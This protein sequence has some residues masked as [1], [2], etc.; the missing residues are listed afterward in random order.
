CALGVVRD[1]VV[2]H[3]KGYGQASLELAVPITAA[4]V[5]DIGSV[6][7]QIT[8]AS[9]VLLA[10]QGKLALDDDVRKFVPD[11]PDYGRKITLRHLLHHTS[12]LRNYVTLLT[13]AGVQKESVTTD[14]DA[15]AF[16]ARQKGLNFAPGDDHLY[17][18]T[19]YFLLSQVIKKVSGK[20]LREF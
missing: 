5:F 14:A 8:A 10:Q 7:K 4:T 16:I 19:G 6:S 11:V 15:L 20:T 9:I 18:N 12:G 2:V 3:T 17:S 1:D 13:L